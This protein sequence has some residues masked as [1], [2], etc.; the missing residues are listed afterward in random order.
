MAP[1]GPIRGTLI[2]YKDNPNG[3]VLT[4]EHRMG[5]YTKEQG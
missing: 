4:L 3:G 1:R 5:K 2:A